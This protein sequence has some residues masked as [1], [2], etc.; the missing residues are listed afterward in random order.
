MTQSQRILTHLKR[1]RRLDPLTALRKFGTSRLAAR[2]CELR[3]AG[4]R[5]VTERRTVRTG[6]GASVVAFY[7][8]A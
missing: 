2:V 4:H 7:R 5:I 8:L 1:G 6:S 3:A